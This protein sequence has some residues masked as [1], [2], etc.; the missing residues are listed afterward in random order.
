MFRTWKKYGTVRILRD[1]PDSETAAADGAPT[2]GEGE[3]STAPENT[4]PAKEGGDTGETPEEK[5]KLEITM[6]DDTKK[7]LG[8]DDK[9]KEQAS[10]AEEGKDDDPSDTP[11]TDIVFAEDSTLSKEQQS[12]LSDIFGTNEKY[13]KGIAWLQDISSEQVAKDKEAA[14][15]QEV[16]WGESLKKDES[17]GK[18]YNENIKLVDSFVDE[19]SDEFK[20]AVNLK[21]P[22]V[23]KQLHL[24][25]KERTDADVHISN[26]AKA[27]QK[28]SHDRFGKPNFGFDK[29]MEALSKRK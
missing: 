21:N 9:E 11:S 28:P 6:S 8:I 17:F 23:I 7:E 4:T 26:S 12:E 18:N 15:K 29:T 2:P 16:E 3:G 22:A 13:Q 19:L 14:E 27:S 24:I 20:E 5:A 10:K 25:A 1:A